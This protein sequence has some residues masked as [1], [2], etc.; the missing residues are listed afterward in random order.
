MNLGSILSE[1]SGEPCAP[2]PVEFHFMRMTAQGRE[3]HRIKAILLP[4]SSSDRA[5]ARRDAQTYLRS[6]P[7]YAEREDP[8]GL[9]KVVPPIPAAVLDE[10]FLLKFLAY[11]LHQ[12]DNALAK[13]VPGPDYP[14]LRA[15]LTIEQVVWLHKRYDKYIEAQYPEMVTAQ[16]MGELERQ[17]AGK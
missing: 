9:G 8:Q 1:S 12:E 6:L 14:L 3:R 4:V 10:E 16:D 15:G 7:E 13:L 5:A 2:E 11:A 17:A